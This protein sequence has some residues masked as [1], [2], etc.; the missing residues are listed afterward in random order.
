MIY[1]VISLVVL[2]A[3]ILAVLIE[4]RS[5]IH[6]VW[7]IPFCLGLMTGTYVW[8]NSMFGYATDTFDYEKKFLFLSYWIDENEE[9]IFAW[10]VFFGDEEPRAIKYPYTDEDHKALEEASQKMQDGERYIGELQENMFSE[11]DSGMADYM[12]AE[13]TGK[14]AKGS[15]KSD[16]GQMIL[17]PISAKSFGFTKDRMEGMP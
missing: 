3:L 2:C 16:G 1:I 6:L 10:V 13:E 5:S 8:A 15:K 14:S 17:T 12:E 11:L 4:T 9:N 7:I